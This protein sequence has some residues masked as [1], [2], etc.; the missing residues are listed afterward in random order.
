MVEADEMSENHAGSALRIGDWILGIARESRP[1]ELMVEVTTSCNYQ[2]IY[3]FRNN[4][5]GE[6][7][8]HMMTPETFMKV[9]ENALEAGVEKIS[10]SG[11]GEP[12]VNPNIIEFI[13]IAKE[14][15]LRVLLN[16]NGYYLDKYLDDIYRL[17]VDELVVSMDSD[18]DDLY[19]LLRRGG[20]LGRIVDALLRLKKYRVRDTRRSPD[21]W[22]NFT[23][24]KYNY[25]NIVPMIKLAEKL[26]ARML[27]VS[28]MIPLSKEMEEITCYSNEDCA[29]TIEK[30]KTMLATL[31]LTHNVVISLPDIRLRTE[32]RC[33]FA[34]DKALYIRWDGK[35]APCIY[36]AHHWRNYF[37]GI[38]REIY[39]VILG[40]LKKDRLIDIWRSPEYLRLRFMTEFSHMPSCLDCPVRDYCILTRD[41]KADCWG[42]T[43]TCAHCPYSRNMTRC[44]L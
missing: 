38:E 33:P 25:K 36:Y 32:R 14:K 24:T 31:S 15:G 41:N 34:A 42:N 43:P 3:C 18:E 27:V 5:I 40:D 1:K 17:G 20:D 30:L 37:M 44:P 7:L 29:E 6:K 28:N 19:R 12:L 26:G 22:I 23:L 10:F 21:L 2:C 39:P 35:V 11:W 4:I 9:V 8:T 13:R 16:T